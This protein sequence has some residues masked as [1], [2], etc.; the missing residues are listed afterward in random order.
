MSNPEDDVA[1]IER[2]TAALAGPLK[3]WVL[4][5]DTCGSQS[6]TL[7]WTREGALERAFADFKNYRTPVAQAYYDRLRQQ[8]HVCI[9]D[10]NF[11]TIEHQEI[12]Q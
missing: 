10:E 6:I 12:L 3:V 7:H 8:G 4:H 5:M 2:V 9:H 11:Y 1:T